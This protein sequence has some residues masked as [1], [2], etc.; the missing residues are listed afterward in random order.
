MKE[1]EVCVVL[2]RSDACSEVLYQIVLQSFP[3]SHSCVTQQ[4]H[5]DHSWNNLLNMWQP[6]SQHRSFTHKQAQSLI[7]KLNA[8]S[9]S[10]YCSYQVFLIW[11][12]VAWAVT[13]SGIWAEFVWPN[14]C[15]CIMELSILRDITLSVTVLTASVQRAAIRRELH[16]LPLFCTLLVFFCHCFWFLSVILSQQPVSVLLNKRSCSERCE[17]EFVHI[18]LS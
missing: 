16:P 3:S 9:L 13:F 12:V 18:S 11:A 8:T 5:S 14:G 2:S 17:L 1:F 15:Y 6:W 10:H 7:Q 4:S